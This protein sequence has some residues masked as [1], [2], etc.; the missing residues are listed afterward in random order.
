MAIIIGWTKTLNAVS[1]TDMATNS[2]LVAC[3]LRLDNSLTANAKPLSTKD[4]TTENVKNKKC[5]TMFYSPFY[6]IN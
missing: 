6:F 5:N 1:D 4:T 2:T 3:T